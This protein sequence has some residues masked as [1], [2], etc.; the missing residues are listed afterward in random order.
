MKKQRSL[1][2]IA[3][4]IAELQK[5]LYTLTGSKL[6]VPNS[7]ELLTSVKEQSLDDKIDFVLT[8]LGIPASINGYNMIHA[9]LKYLDKANKKIYYTK[10][11]Y[12]D[13]ATKFSKTP[14]AVERNIHHAILIVCR[15][16]NIDLIKQLFPHITEISKGI[17][18]NIF[19]P[20]I[21]EYVKKGY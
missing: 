1:K 5:E 4:L 17:P 10:E 20:R 16:G 14:T 3:N 8:E 7:T 19:L 6:F 2:K 18:N 21:L 12:P 9:A 11:L 13:I 15:K